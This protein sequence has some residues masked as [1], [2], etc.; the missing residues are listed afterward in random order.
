MLA[1]RFTKH[2]ASHIYRRKGIRQPVR[3]PCLNSPIFWVAPRICFTVPLY[4]QYYFYGGPLCYA[5]LAYF[6]NV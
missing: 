5:M 3:A 1:H 6:S 4:L 2:T